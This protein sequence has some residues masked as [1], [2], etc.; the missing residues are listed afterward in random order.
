MSPGPAQRPQSISFARVRL[1]RL[2]DAGSTRPSP[3]AALASIANSATSAATTGTATPP[4]SG[5]I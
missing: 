5:S 2:A 4:G 3:D 1:A